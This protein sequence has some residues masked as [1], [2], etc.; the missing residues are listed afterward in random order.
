MVGRHRWMRRG[1][2]V[3]SGAVAALVMTAALVLAGGS[4]PAEDRLPAVAVIDFRVEGMLARQEP[5]AGELVAERLRKQVDPAA[6]RVL[7]R[8]QIVEALKALNLAMVDLWVEMDLVHTFG[9]RAGVRYVVLG[10]VL[11]RGAE[12]QVY[13]RLVDCQQERAGDERRLALRVDE[14]P[15]AALARL[16]QG[17]GL[18]SCGPAEDEAAL[19]P[20]ETPEEEPE[21]EAGLAGWPS[22]A[23]C[24]EAYRKLAAGQLPLSKEE[25]GLLEALA[26]RMTMTVDLKGRW[27]RD[28]QMLIDGNPPV[29]KKTS[30]LGGREFFAVEPGRHTLTFSAKDKD[31]L[32]RNLHFH[33]G[34][35]VEVTLINP[36]R[37]V[38]VS[39]WQRKTFSSHGAAVRYAKEHDIRLLYD[40]GGR[41]LEVYDPYYKTVGA[42]AL[43]LVEKATPLR[44]IEFRESYDKPLSEDMEALTA[45]VVEMCRRTIQKRLALVRKEPPIDVVSKQPLKERVE[46]FEGRTQEEDA[47]RLLGSLKT[48]RSLAIL[49]K[50]HLQRCRP[51]HTSLC[52]FTRA[53]NDLRKSAEDRFERPA[54]RE[55]AQRLV[56]KFE[57]RPL[58]LRPVRPM[59][60]LHQEHVTRCPKTRHTCEFTQA[61][62][63]A[64]A[65]AG[66]RSADA[67]ARKQALELLGQYEFRSLD[68][69][70]INC[71][72]DPDLAEPLGEAVRAFFIRAGLPQLEEARKAS[73]WQLAR[74][75]ALSKPYAPYL[76][77][78]E[79]RALC[80]FIVTVTT[81]GGAVPAQNLPQIRRAAAAFLA[82]MKG[83]EPRDLL[84]KLAA[85]DPSLRSLLP[86]GE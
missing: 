2:E 80:A 36:E 7:T 45:H 47:A 3:R 41:T 30:G 4:A 20:P 61:L 62:D 86:E 8:E 50:W 23:A 81:E 5:K 79:T 26:P 58:T 34:M 85:W 72:R 24:A 65:T 78:S 32:S 83:A 44:A 14:F 39:R 10:R 16:V 63:A 1:G 53:L 84:R 59:S 11:K 71:R 42:R 54:L 15:A 49:Q 27:L 46:Y 29:K 18:K 73:A 70:V 67:A 76:G 60:V 74:L 66:S 17:L 6:Y 35:H 38:L 22:A 64:H 13:A 52:H 12:W 77:E 75:L 56:E 40:G 33:P 48:E 57:Y 51:G 68:T 21:P 69:V 82:E 28:V 9:E 19:L 55:R 25:Q 37:E 43:R 31:P